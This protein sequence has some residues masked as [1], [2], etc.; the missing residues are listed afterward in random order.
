[1][2]FN[3]FLSLALELA[4]NDGTME[5]ADLVVFPQI[6]QGVASQ[7]ATVTYEHL[8]TITMLFGSMFL[9]VVSRLGHDLAQVTEHG[10]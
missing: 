5:A 8:A 9:V 7:V 4:D 10:Q 2:R 3:Q 1:M 6:V